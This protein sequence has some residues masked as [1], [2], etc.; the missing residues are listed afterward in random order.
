MFC[1]QV[2]VVVPRGVLLS[3]ERG[4]PQTKRAVE[5]MS[6]DDRPNKPLEEVVPL[7]NQE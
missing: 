3:S 7:F 1:Y 5:L 4:R 6:A 2:N